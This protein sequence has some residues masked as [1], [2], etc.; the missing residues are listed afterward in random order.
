MRCA[1]RVYFPTHRFAYLFNALQIPIFP[2]YTTYRFQRS[3]VLQQILLAC[4]GIPHPATRIYYG[5]RQKAKIPDAFP[6]PFVAMGP[7]LASQRKHLIN[8]PT[9]LDEYSRSCNPL[10]IQEAVE[11]IERVHILCIH[12]DCVGAVRQGGRDPVDSRYE[13]ISLEQ[14]ERRSL[15]EPTRDF[16]R[17]VHLDDIVIEW[18]YGSGQWQLLEMRRP[19]V[20][21]PMAE[22]TLNRHQYLCKL[23]ESGR[24]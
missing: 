14:L 9:A 12:D 23:V 21:W 18:A 10:I 2:T 13:P 7:I 6:F 5:S 24:L 15:L 3:R 16:I 4:V 11:W 19:P 20:Q 1:E 17:K 8:T 22:G